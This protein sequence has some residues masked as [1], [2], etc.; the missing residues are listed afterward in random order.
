MNA[1]AYLRVSGTSQIDGTGFERQ[2][3]QC[4]QL[5]A[6]KDFTLTRVFQEK[7]IPGWKDEDERPAFQE[8]VAYLLD[9]QTNVLIIESLDRL[10][11]AYRV[12]EQ[13]ILYLAAKGF[14]LWAANT[15][16]DI[17]AA[18]LGDPMKKALVQIQGIFAE[19]DKN[20]L[21]AKL[22]KGRQIVKAREGRCEGQKP[23]GHY[24]DE[25]LTLAGMVANREC[26][27]TYQQ[28]ADGLNSRPYLKSRSGNPWTAHMVAKILRR[29]RVTRNLRP[30][31]APEGQTTLVM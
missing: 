4:R 13:L 10:A 7:A 9:T 20:L 29:E 27:L 3:A 2:D 28:I 12:Q 1:V 14:T 31:C 15:E 6:S 22:R 26:G 25:G 23:Y 5:A 21:V 19:L 11:R 24:G 30:A 18:V 17:T 16:E 8:M